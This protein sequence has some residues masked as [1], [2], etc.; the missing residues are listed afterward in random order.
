MEPPAA[1]EE[2]DTGLCI[3]FDQ[4]LVSISDIASPFRTPLTQ[5]QCFRGICR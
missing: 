2:K 1:L 4:L 5:E 3:A